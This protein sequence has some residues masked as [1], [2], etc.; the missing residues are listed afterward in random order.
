MKAITPLISVSITNMIKAKCT[1][2]I[3]PEAMVVPLCV[4]RLE[5]IDR[6][7]FEI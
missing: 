4:K 6:R 1:P 7:A 2:V 5:E 3:F